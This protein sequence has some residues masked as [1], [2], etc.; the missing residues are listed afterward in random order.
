MFS[1]VSILNMFVPGFLSGECI[2]LS[3]L[4]TGLTHSFVQEKLK[5]KNRMFAISNEELTFLLARKE[6]E[7][8]A[9]NIP[10]LLK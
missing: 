10:F 1:V 4:L 3:L 2:K 7:T 6:T 8:F 9:P 5:C